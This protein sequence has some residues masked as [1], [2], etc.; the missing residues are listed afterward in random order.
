MPVSLTGKIIPLNA[1]F[2]GM[3]DENQIIDTAATVGN[4]MKSGG[5]YFASSAAGYLTSVGTGVANEITYWSGTNTLGSLTTST[6]PSLTELSYVKGVTSAIQT[7]LG[8]KQAS[9]A[10]LTSLAGL[11]YVS[12][13]F[14][15]MTS[16]DTFTLD[17]NTY[18]TSVT[19]HNLLSATHGDTTASTVARGDVVVGTGASPTWDNLAL[20]TVGKILRSNGTDLLYSTATFA[21][22][23]TASNLLYSNGANTVTGLATT[24]SGILITNGTGVPSIATDIPTA[25]TIGSYYI[26]RVGGTDV[27]VTDGGTALSTIAAGSALC[28]NTLNTVVAVTSTSGTKVLTNTSGTITWET[29]SGGG[30]PGGNDTQLQYNDGGSFGGL[31]MLTWNDTDFLLGAASATKLKFRDSAIYINSLADT[32]LDFQA[33]GA[34][35]FANDILGDI[36]FTFSSSTSNT[37]TLT[38]KE[39]EGYF[40]FSNDILM[41]GAEKIYFGTTGNYLYEASSGNVQLISTSQLVFQSPSIALSASS[42]L[43]LSQA[44]LISNWLIDSDYN[45][46]FGNIYSFIKYDPTLEGLLIQDDNV[47]TIGKAGTIELGDSILRIMRPQTDGKIDLG[48]SDQAFGSIYFNGA[49]TPSNVT[50]LTIVSDVITITGTY[51]TVDTENDASSDDVDTISGGVTNQ[52]LILRPADGGRTVVLKNGTGNLNLHADITLD[53]DRDVVI[54]IYTGTVWYP[55]MGG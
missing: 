46:Q 2:T 30:S 34:F 10:G 23:Y 4:I 1:G 54:L 55:I 15:K 9:D 26:Y 37:G 53:D 28:A 12:T 32:F 40:L 45:I 6:Y 5:V 21:D 51:H 19:A 49:F 48:Q 13:A 29:A 3:V 47:V 24:N 14:V 43:S 50:E 25:I 27:A 17:T 44:K 8:N 11:T 38:W 7:Q 22:T 18:L 52:L 36:T 16:A 42:G 33:D 35:R 20:G 41:N 31:S 39:H